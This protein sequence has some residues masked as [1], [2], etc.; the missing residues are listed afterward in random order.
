MNLETIKSQPAE[1]LILLQK[2]SEMLEL[3]EKEIK[4]FKEQIEWLKRQLFGRK[5]ERFNP[6]QLCFDFLIDALE[7]RPPSEPEAAVE[8]R[9]SGHVRKITPHGRGIIPDH[10]DSVIVEV[11][12]PEEQKTLPDGR[13][14]P[15]IGY[16]D[17][18]KLAYDPAR[19]YVKITRRYKYG[20]PSHVESEEPGVLQAPLPE[21][22]LPRCLADDTMLAHVAVSKYGDH[23]PAYR[24]EQIFKRSGVNIARQTLCG[25]MVALGIALWPV[26]AAIKRE[27]FRTGLIH[28]DDTPVEL[29]EADERKPESKKIRTARMWVS[30]AGPRDGPWTVFDFTVTREADGPKRF[31]KDYSGKIVCDAYS[32]Y[33]SL[34]EPDDGANGIV[35]YG[36]WAHVRRYFFNAY[37]GG[38]RK[39][40]AEFVAL[41]KLLYDV[42]E[43]IR[44]KDDISLE[45]ILNTRQKKSRPV[46]D[47]IKHKIDALLLV[48]PPKSLLGKA[49]NYAKNYWD[50]LTRYVDDPQAA[51]DNNTAEN[52]IRPIAIGRKN[53]L[54]IGSRDAG[55]A[56]ANI[57]SIICTC[58]R[59][60]VEPYAYMLDVIRRLPSMKTS[61]L[62]PLL[63]T[64]WRKH[65]HADKAQQTAAHSK[66]KGGHAE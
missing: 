60:G 17:S 45:E 9:V 39:N 47:N 19:I 54:F 15:C 10:L 25:W 12:I 32:G 57:M 6:N 51:I 62:E 18:K 1:A 64:N 42:E 2:Q 53:W 44:G 13:K 22:L 30:S 5:S 11:D 36:C 8:T 31:F 24:L 3:Y 34:A 59:A 49:L 43:E 35:L 52:A 63:P 48:T 4:S 23:L 38:D 56:A 58:K 27:L 55:E 41:I 61:E 66:Y 50:R 21:T 29:L 65:Q 26:V 20:N 7:N 14:R 28:S 37:K 46:L 40:G 33:G 16:D